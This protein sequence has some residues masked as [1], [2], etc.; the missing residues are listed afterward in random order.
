MFNDSGNYTCDASKV[1]P[2]SVM[3]HVL[4]GEDE[5]RSI[6]SRRKA[7]PLHRRKKKKKKKEK[8]RFIP[9]TSRDPVEAS[10]NLEIL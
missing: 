2:A 4:N 5:T 6:K 8:S 10:K 1:A 7:S 9:S 3:V